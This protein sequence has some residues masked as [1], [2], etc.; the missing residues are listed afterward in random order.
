MLVSLD[1]AVLPI[2]NLALAPRDRQRIR[3]L[4]HDGGLHGYDAFG[5]HASGVAAGLALTDPLYRAWFRVRSRN[6]CHLP[7]DGPAIVVGN[8][9]GLLPFDGL[10]LWAD[11]VRQSEPLRIPRFIVDNFVLRLPF[12]SP[13]YARS[14]AVGGS[15][16]NV[17][18]LLDRGELVVIFPEGTNGIATTGSDECGPQFWTVGH[19]E[20]AIRH[21][22]P[23]IPVAIVG[24]ERQFPLAIR[25][26][27][28]A[29]GSPWIPLAFPPW[30]LPVQYRIVYGEPIALHSRWTA[31]DADSPA[32]VHEAA[33]LVRASVLSL[34]ESVRRGDA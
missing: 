18:H 25:L 13:F 4:R 5:L 6:A 9:R 28:R 20:M 16:G 1:R 2:A 30:P 19:A 22:A 8:H 14:G 26:P 34:T 21:R 11:I 32:A 24:P 27:I 33:A 10:M 31:A 15:R 3:G 29:F 7:A 23:V 12:V 17:H